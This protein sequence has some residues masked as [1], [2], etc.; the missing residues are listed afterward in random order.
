MVTGVLLFVAAKLPS[1]PEVPRPQVQRVPSVL[2]AAV[3][4]EPQAT[5][6]QL[7][8]PENVVTGVLL[9][10][11]AKLPSCPKV[12]PPQV[13]KDPSVLIAAV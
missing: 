12:P 7:V 2:I 11:V 5:C 3:Y 6:F 10:V 9:F 13:H 4:S 8:P 1:C